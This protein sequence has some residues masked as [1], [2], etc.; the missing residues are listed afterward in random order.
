VV[1]CEQYE[2]REAAHA[3]PC[4][5][6]SSPVAAA[7]AARGVHRLFSHQAVAVDLL[8]Q[9]SRPLQPRG[10]PSQLFRRPG[11]P[12]ILAVARALPW[13]RGRLPK[14]APRVAGSLLTHLPLPT[15]PSLCSLQGVHCC[16]ATSTASGKSLCY[17]IPVLEELMCD[18]GACALFIFPT[19]ALAQVQAPLRGCSRC[20][21]RPA[22][23]LAR[24]NGLPG[25]S[26]GGYVFLLG[27]KCPP[28]RQLLPRRCRR[29]LEPAPLPCTRPTRPQDQLR[30]L[31]VL[32]GATLGDRAPAIDIYDG[33]TPQADR[34][35]IRARAQ[36]LI[37]NPDMLHVSVLPCHREFGRLLR[38]LRYVVVDEAHVYKGESEGRGPG[39]C[40]TVC[41]RC[42]V[43]LGPAPGLVVAS[44]RGLGA[45]SPRACSPQGGGHEPAGTWRCALEDWRQSCGARRFGPLWNRVCCRLIPPCAAPPHAACRRVWVPRGSGAAAPAA[46]VCP[47]LLQLPHV[48]GDHRHAGQP[49][50]ARCGAAGGRQRAG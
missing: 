33:D 10:S 28:S 21:G 11:C 39:N 19:K 30:S 20:C 17:Q 27:R 16:V 40:C 15:H 45:A 48:C 50:G 12:C 22:P 5:P 29:L 32:A 35:D 26:P 13:P 18:P 37:T 23:V 38:A 8:R 43:V 41:A 3:D 49:G 2:A 24:M 14:G 9:A 47:G 4:L 1:H 25:S 44:A 34:G 7:L 42:S 36:L 31:R 46:P 6:L